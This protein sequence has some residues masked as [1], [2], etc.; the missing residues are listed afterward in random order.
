MKERG[1]KNRYGLRS[2]SP[3]PI[4]SESVTPDIP[5]NPP[6]LAPPPAPIPQWGLPHLQ[7]GNHQVAATASQQFGAP[8]MFPNLPPTIGN[9]NGLGTFPYPMGYNLPGIGFAAPQMPNSF[10]PPLVLPSYPGFPTGEFYSHLPQ[11]PIYPL[12][13]YNISSPLELPNRQPPQSHRSQMTWQR[14]RSPYQQTQPNIEHPHRP[15]YYRSDPSPTFYPDDPSNFPRLMQWLED[16]DQDTDRGQWQD[17]FSQFTARFEMER[18]TTLLDLEGLTAEY[19]VSITG[20]SH[21]SAKR[22]IRFATEDIQ[23]IRDNVPRP[24]KRTRYN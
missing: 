18:F 12:Q 8:L 5:T 17:D 22:L 16:V 15:S 20:I 14:P 9:F 21:D 19:L 6:P 13:Q 11:P 24:S 3:H 7:A 23:A 1:K 2:P 4:D 10:A